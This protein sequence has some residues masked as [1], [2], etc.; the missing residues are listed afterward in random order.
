MLLGLAYFYRGLCLDKGMS[1]KV[2]GL[3]LRDSWKCDGEKTCSVLELSMEKMVA[4][5]QKE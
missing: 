1:N 5:G 4:L 3:L 2:S